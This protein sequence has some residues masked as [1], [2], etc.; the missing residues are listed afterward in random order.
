MYVLFVC[1]CVHVWPVR[2]CMYM[3]AHVSMC[4]C[5]SVC[6]GVTCACVHVC[7]CLHMCLCVPVCAGVTCAC[8]HVCLCVS[9]RVSVCTHKYFTTH[10]SASS[11]FILQQPFSLFIM[12][13]GTPQATPAHRSPD[14]QLGKEEMKPPPKRS[15]SLTLHSECA[16]V[17]LATRSVWE[18]FPWNLAAKHPFV[19]QSLSFSASTPPEV[20]HLSSLLFNDPWCFYSHAQLQLLPSNLNQGVWPPIFGRSTPLIINVGSQPHPLSVCTD[21][22]KSEVNTASQIRLLLSGSSV[23]F[24]L[25]RKPVVFLW[26]KDIWGQH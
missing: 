13:G 1:A 16:S 10:D 15:F 20:R 17:Y 11:S 18:D 19:F 21:G 25:S 3:R 5:V 23:T 22:R 24:T 4:A 2:V 9:A 8:V 7:L 14:F 6:A 12:S 26:G